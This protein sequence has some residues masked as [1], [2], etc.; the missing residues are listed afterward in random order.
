MISY[1]NKTYNFVNMV[2]FT[3]LDSRPFIIHLKGGTGLNRVLGEK[4]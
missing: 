4:R 2:M 3:H 1:F